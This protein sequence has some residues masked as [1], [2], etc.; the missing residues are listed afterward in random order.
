M[1]DLHIIPLYDDASPF[2]DV[3]Q[4]FDEPNG[5]LAAGGNLSTQRLVLAYKSGIFP[6]YNEN[7][8]I[9]WWSP[10]PRMVLFP[11]Q[12]KVSRSLKKVIKNSGY[13][14]FFDRSFKTV[15]AEC[16]ADRKGQSGTWIHQ[17]MLHAYHKLHQLGIAHSVETWYENELVGG[18]YGLAIGK[19]FFGES[20]FFRKK[21]ASKVAFATLVKQ[22]Q[23][24]NFL[25]IDCQIYT[26]HLASLGAVNIP[27]NEF[28]QL[29]TRYCDVDVNY[30]SWNKAIR[31][32]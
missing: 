31:P 27:R 16:A 13:Q 21:D 25:L 14:V 8:P 18:L 32:Q 7:E 30:E 19:V 28:T 3:N 22:L 4:A 23:Q 11:E 20:M 29:V 1:S 9:L 15:M 2:P 17:E 5:L 24:W 26:S 10:D 12:L 6:W